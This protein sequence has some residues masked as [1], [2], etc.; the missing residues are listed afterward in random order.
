MRLDAVGYGAGTRDPR[1]RPN[2][3]RVL[4]GETEQQHDQDDQD[5]LRQRDLTVLEANLDDLTPELVAD[6]AE[7]LLAAGAL[8]VWTSPVQMKKGR[9]AVLLAALCEP[10]READLRRVFFEST[11][12]FGVRAHDVRRAELERR[13]VA[14]D[15][16]DGTVRVKVGLLGAKVVT[17]MPEHDDVAALAA[18]TGRPVRAVYEEAAAMALTLRL[19][20]TSGS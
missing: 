10:H 5:G 9:P 7:A 2:V 17:V 4:L 13:T 12:T 14:A 8:D 19:E 11:S 3:V 16:G 6:A 15:L 20:P 1:H 18:R